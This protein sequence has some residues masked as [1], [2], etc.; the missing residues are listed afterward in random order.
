LLRQISSQAAGHKTLVPDLVAELK[1]QGAED[2]V[3]VVGG[4]I[5]PDDYD[6]L[7]KSGVS[8]IFGP[9]RP[10][11]PITKP[12]NSSSHHVRIMGRR[13]HLHS[14]VVNTQARASRTLRSR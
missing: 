8:C 3:V 11:P 5:P 14:L 7:Y 1:K 2:V 10:P 12:S 9:G 13:S 6:F 4:V